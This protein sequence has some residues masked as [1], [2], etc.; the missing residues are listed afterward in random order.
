MGKK[1]ILIIPERCTGCRAC[2][3]ACKNWNDLPAVTTKF[4]GNFNSPPALTDGHI[5]RINFTE[6]P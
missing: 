5:T 2:Q 1:S 4:P 3:V 6:I